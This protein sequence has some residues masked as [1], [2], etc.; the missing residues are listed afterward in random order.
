MQ[1]LSLEE[2]KRLWRLLSAPVEL[3][4]GLVPLPLHPEGAEACVSVSLTSLR[5]LQALVEQVR[6]ELHPQPEPGFCPRCR[7][8]VDYAPDSVADVCPSC[9]G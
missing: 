5:R 6:E 1:G 9:L 2:R 3:A 7:V 4:T 8:H